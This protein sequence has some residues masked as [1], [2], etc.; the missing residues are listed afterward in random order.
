MGWANVARKALR[1]IAVHRKTLKKVR[2]DQMRKH[3]L[4][5]G[6]ALRPAAPVLPCAAHRVP[7]SMMVAVPFSA[8]GSRIVSIFFL[9]CGKFISLNWG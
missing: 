6:H 7:C 3:R 1:K 8:P 5:D 2:H 9:T 4:A